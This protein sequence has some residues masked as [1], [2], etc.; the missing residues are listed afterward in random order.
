MTW[1][2]IIG[3]FAVIQFV[4]RKIAKAQD[5][6]IEELN[7]LKALEKAKYEFLNRQKIEHIRIKVQ[8]EIAK[9]K[10]EA[11]EGEKTRTVYYPM[12]VIC[13]KDLRNEEIIEDNEFYFCTDCY[14]EQ[15]L[16]R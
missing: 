2:Y 16:K 9:Q 11:A 4:F 14:I 6:K 3:A 5:G 13:R 12:C 10:R 15:S 8:D 1:I 7:L